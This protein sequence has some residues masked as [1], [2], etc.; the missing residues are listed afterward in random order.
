MT[1]AIEILVD[2]SAIEAASG[3]TL[4]EACD[5]AGIYI[6]RLCSYPGLVCC[7]GSGLGGRECGLCAVKVTAAEEGAPD[8][9]GEGPG[10]IVLACRTLVAPGLRIVT[11]DTDIDS[12]RLR[13][14]AAVMGAHPHVCLT[15][16]DR[17]GCARNVCTFGHVPEARC[18][19]EFGRC[20][21]GRLC[22]YLDRSGTLDGAV[23]SVSRESAT[24]G[25]IR[26][27]P[28]LCVGC[29]RCL[30]VCW[31]AEGGGKALEMG[32]DERPRPTQGMLRASG[33]TF[34]GQCV[35]VC[36]TGALTAPGEA[37]V[38]WLAGRRE[39]SG[40]A[41]TVLPPELWLPIDSDASASLPEGPGVFRLLDQSGTVLY[42]AGVADLRRGM[43]LAL[44]EPTASSAVYFDFEEDPLYTQ[45]ESELLTAFAQR[46][47]HLPPGNDMGDDL[48]GDDLD[49]LDEDL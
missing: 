25:R 41:G 27:E 46:H 32:P 13:H 6:P 48:F 44:R 43:A 11:S 37:G 34:C 18:C 28:G 30:T 12:L 39:R 2:G 35:I 3:T 17:D 9:L 4:L 21:I 36:P 38:A 31:H 7:A 26:R 23:V 40:L 16:P 42:I 19:D 49:D 20:E 15:C 45:R 14:L 22:A 24:E 29:G 1:G 33:C 8:A 10:E 47:G 5:A